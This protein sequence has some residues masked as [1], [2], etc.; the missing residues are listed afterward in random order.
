MGVVGEDIVVEALER[1]VLSGSGGAV[2]ELDDRIADGNTDKD[3]DT[4]VAERVEISRDIE[5]RELSSSALSR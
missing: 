1:G 3:F 2:V 5:L 4:G